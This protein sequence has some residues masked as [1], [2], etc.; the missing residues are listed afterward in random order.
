MMLI[1][2]GLADTIVIT[3]CGRTNIQNVCPPDTDIIP[4]L[5]HLC[6][7]NHHICVCI[8]GSCNCIQVISCT[9]PECAGADTVNGYK[10]SV[11][12]NPAACQL[13]MMRSIGI[14]GDHVRISFLYITEVFCHIFPAV[15]L[16]QSCSFRP[17]K[18]VNETM[19]GPLCIVIFR[20]QINFA[21]ISAHIPMFRAYAFPCFRS[22]GFKHI[23]GQFQECAV[24]GIR[25][26][27]QP[28]GSS[29]DQVYGTVHLSQCQVII[30]KIIGP[31][32]EVNLK[33]SIY[34]LGKD[35][36]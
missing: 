28:V 10:I 35:F 25:P 4:F 17:V 23:F 36:V 29:S 9:A 12:R 2:C 21:V 18:T 22:I 5:H 13:C 7:L 27:I 8:S 24:L 19:V 30:C 34:F 14:P 6:K 31:G 20:H 11:G 26:C 1:R 3:G 33:L 32:N 16:I 15:N